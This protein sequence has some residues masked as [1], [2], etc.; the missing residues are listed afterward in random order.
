MVLSRHRI[1]LKEAL[2][3]FSVVLV[4]AFGGILAQSSYSAHRQIV[5]DAARAAESIVRAAETSTGR[6][7][8]SID[9]MLIGIDQALGSVYRSAPIDGPTVQS[10][11]RRMNDQTPS[12]RDI[13]ILDAS[14]RQVNGAKPDLG[15]TNSYAGRAFFTSHGADR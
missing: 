1:G 10:L 11:L 4:L 3:A 8:A 12:V 7:I 5:S 14:G 6:T 2:A 15:R 13:L 9:A